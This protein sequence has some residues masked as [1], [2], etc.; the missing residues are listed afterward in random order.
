MTFSQSSN[1]EKFRQSLSVA[2]VEDDADDREFICAAL[3][4]AATNLKIAT[5]NNGA[6]FIKHIS[7]D[8]A[9]PQF[10]ITDIRMPLVSGFE[11]IRT[12][13]SDERC[14]GIPVVVLSTSDNPDDVSKAKELGAAEY[15]VKPYSMEEYCDVIAKMLNDNFGDGI[16]TS[17]ADSF[18]ALLALIGRWWFPPAPLAAGL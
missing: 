2:V 10:V 4:E 9:L 11:L 15:Y 14:A 18:S 17:G 1:I 16:T 12:L 13:K 3:R 6:D 5:F 8:K 7:A